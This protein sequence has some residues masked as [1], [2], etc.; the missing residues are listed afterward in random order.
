MQWHL[1]STISP[2][3]TQPFIRVQIKIKHDSSVSLAFVPGIHQ[4][5]VNSPYKWP[6]TLKMF[7]FVDIIMDTLLLM[8]HY[9]KIFYTWDCNILTDN[10]AMDISLNVVSLKQLRNNNLQDWCSCV[11]PKSPCLSS[12]T[13]W[14]PGSQALLPHLLGSLSIWDHWLDFGEG[15][16]LIQTG[17]HHMISPGHVFYPSMAQQGLG[18]WEQMLHV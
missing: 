10:Q 8:W 5:L 16:W 4:W 3:F 18:Q 2:L 14:L 15:S 1:K 11:W 7:R 17:K 13:P 6:V 12:I 9:Y